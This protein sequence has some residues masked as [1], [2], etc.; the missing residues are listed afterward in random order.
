MSTGYSQRGNRSTV[1]ILVPLFYRRQYLAGMAFYLYF[2]ENPFNDS[3]L[4]Y[5]EC[6]ALDAHIFLA[7]HALFF[8]DSISLGGFVIRIGKKCERKIEFFFEL[9]LSLRS[10]RRDSYNHRVLFCELLAVV[11]E[12]AGLFCATRSV[13]P[14]I[15]IQHHSLSSQR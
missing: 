8:P 2:G 10:I 15:E 4:V 6:S 7:V 14:G 3:V 5:Q 13:G 11:P 12:S 1:Q 9:R